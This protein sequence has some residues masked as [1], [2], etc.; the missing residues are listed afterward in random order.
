VAI[1]RNQAESR[2]PASPRVAAVGR[3]YSTTV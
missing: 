2:D 3:R 1:C